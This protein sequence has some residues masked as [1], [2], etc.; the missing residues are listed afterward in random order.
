MWHILASFNRSIAPNPSTTPERI[1]CNAIPECVSIAQSRPIPLQ[2]CASFAIAST[3]KMCFNRSIAPNPSTTYA[4]WESKE[5][6][7]Q[8]SF[9]RSI[10]PNP[11]TTIHRRAIQNII[12]KFQSLN[13][14]QSLYNTIRS[15]HG[16]ICA[17]MVSIAQSRPIPLQLH[18][19]SL[20]S[21]HA[22]AVSIAQSRPI[23]LQLRNSKVL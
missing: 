5:E 8:N 6:E 14:A 16:K 9:N 11:S 15:G 20:S 1:H 10:A 13:R 19:A 7:Y 18:G 23:P 12:Q 3:R 2:P 17:R 21:R 22:Q 4:L